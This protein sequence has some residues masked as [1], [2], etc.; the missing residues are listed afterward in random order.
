MKVLVAGAL[1]DLGIKTCELLLEKG[2][3]VWGL[4][5]SPARRSDLEALGLGPII[6]TCSN[7]N[8]RAPRSHRCGLRRSLPFPSLFPS[9]ALSV[10]AI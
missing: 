6:A 2:H 8:P 7:V 3:E 10:R 9:T 5:R 4:T 1:A